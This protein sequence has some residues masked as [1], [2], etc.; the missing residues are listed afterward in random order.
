MGEG[1][2]SSRKGVCARHVSD[3]ARFLRVNIV[4]KL[5]LIIDINC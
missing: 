4:I 5:F 2:P 3:V 1:V